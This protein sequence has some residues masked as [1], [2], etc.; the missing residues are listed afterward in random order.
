M[1]LPFCHPSS[2]AGG[3]GH[4]GRALHAVVTVKGRFVA[5]DAPGAGCLQVNQ[6]V[7]RFVGVLYLYFIFPYFK[8]T[9]THTK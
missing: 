3:K 4:R 7:V 1:S 9:C 2:V 5:D 6:A 8:K